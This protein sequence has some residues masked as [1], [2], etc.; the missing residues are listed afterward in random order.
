MYN[1]SIS[2]VYCTGYNNSRQPAY[3]FHIDYVFQI[4]II[5]KTKYN[6]HK[7]KSDLAP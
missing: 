4:F 2:K 6:D 7:K 3:I 5:R 1:L